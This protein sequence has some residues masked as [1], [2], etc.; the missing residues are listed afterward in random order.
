MHDRDGR[1]EGNGVELAAGEA[2]K[3]ETDERRVVEFYDLI[4]NK[5]DVAAAQ[6]YIGPYYR[7]HNPLVADGPKG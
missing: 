2:S 6:P 1:E 3:V 7:Q 5:K 4:I